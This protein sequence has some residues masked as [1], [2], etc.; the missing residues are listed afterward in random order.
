VSPAEARGKLAGRAGVIWFMP[1]SVIRHFWYDPA[2][3]KMDV[4]FVSGARYR[5]H[6]VPEE[7]Y[8]SMKRAFSKGQ[9]FNVKVRDRYRFTR[10]N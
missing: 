9:Y 2:H 1:S 7:D 8:L 4:V 6:D 5:Y 3:Q 10:E